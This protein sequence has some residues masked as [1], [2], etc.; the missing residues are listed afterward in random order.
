MTNQ[1]EAKK[2][3][4]QSGVK[5][6]PGPLTEIQTLSQFRNAGTIN[7]CFVKLHYF[8]SSYLPTKSK[9]RWIPT[10]Y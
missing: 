5:I 8:C 6:I 9:T 4:S 3:A 1:L 2:V 10:G 7:L